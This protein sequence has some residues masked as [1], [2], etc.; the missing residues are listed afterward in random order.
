MVSANIIYD[1]SSGIELTFARPYGTTT[2]HDNNVIDYIRS[3][4]NK[5][6]SWLSSSGVTDVE[7]RMQIY[8]PDTARIE[9]TIDY[10][11]SS[12]RAMLLILPTMYKATEFTIRDINYV[13]SIGTTQVYS[14]NAY[15]YGVEGVSMLSNNAGMAGVTSSTVD[16]GAA[17]NPVTTLVSSGN[18][19]Y[20][21]AIAVDEVF[22]EPAEYIVWVRA[23]SSAG[24]TNDLTIS[25]TDTTSGS[26]GTRNV[27]VTTGNY[28]WYG[29]AVTIPST[30]LNHVVNI[31][32]TKATAATN[33]INIDIIS[34]VRASGL[35]S[36]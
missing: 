4:D 34:I 26:L 6:V 11:R 24:T 2:G 35:I 36:L 33:T 27:T 31:A 21:A 3:I 30:S 32:A 29:L 25:V 14:V 16:A 12:G 1:R 18:S 20:M 28:K 10:L 7:F 22:L 13:E 23:K 9:R 5:L 17:S 19:R 15:C 8:S